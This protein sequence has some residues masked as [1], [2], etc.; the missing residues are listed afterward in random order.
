MV[1]LLAAYGVAAAGR[2]EAPGVYVDGAKIAALG[3]RIRDGRC[4][5]GLA[6]NADM[7]LTPFRAID[8]CGYSGLAVTQAREIGIS[9]TP[10][11]LGEKLVRSVLNRLT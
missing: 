5:H 7:D 9:D 3:L 11:L 1:D 8:P 2:H 4:Y 6:F 10:E